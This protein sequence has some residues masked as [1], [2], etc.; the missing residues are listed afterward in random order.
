MIIPEYF[1]SWQSNVLIDHD[2]HVRLADFGLF[3]IAE[4]VNVTFTI[5]NLGSVRWQAPEL[6]A[7]RHDEPDSYRRT[8][9]MDVYSFACVCLEVCG[10]STHHMSRA[11]CSLPRSIQAVTHT[12]V[13][14]MQAPSDSRL[15]MAPGLS[16]Q[17]VMMILECRSRIIYGE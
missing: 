5:A 3:E 1:F 2:G 9:A 13:F 8:R 10:Q 14:S 17:L 6:L 11:E 12:I 4:K 16:V 15:S 7:A